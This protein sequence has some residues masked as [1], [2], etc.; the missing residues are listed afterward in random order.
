MMLETHRGEPHMVINTSDAARIGVSD[1]QMVRVHNDQGEF[2]VMALLS[3]SAQPGQVVMYNGFDAFQF[4]NWA[5]PNDAEPGMVKW[6][7]L[8]GGYGHLKYWVTEWQP[9]PVMRG[10]RVAV[11]PL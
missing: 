4:P 2:Q 1:G 7:H 6:L 11:Q 9:C 3:S 5:G 10:T 8:A